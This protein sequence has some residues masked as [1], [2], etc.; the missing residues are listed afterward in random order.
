M[1]QPIMS[2]D[3]PL[4]PPP[5]HQLTCLSCPT[6]PTPPPA[7][8][9]S[10]QPP[11]SNT[12]LKFDDAKHYYTFL[13]IK[14]WAKPDIIEK[15]FQTKVKAYDSHSAKGQKKWCSENADTR[16]VAQER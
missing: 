6:R 9:S 4:A 11:T 16:K 8:T 7:S 3:G 14:K 15:A 13:N 1:P 5:A 10:S 12:Y 2:M